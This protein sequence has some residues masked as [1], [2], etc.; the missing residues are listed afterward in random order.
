MDLQSLSISELHSLVQQPLVTLEMGLLPIRVS[1]NAKDIP[2]SKTQH[3][4]KG[5]KHLIKAFPTDYLMK[6]YGHIELNKIYDQNFFYF[7]NVVPRKF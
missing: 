7:L 5:A 1:V 3:E 2:N 6:Y 4:N